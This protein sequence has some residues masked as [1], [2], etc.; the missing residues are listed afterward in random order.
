MREELQC[1]ENGAFLLDLYGV[2]KTLCEWL[3]IEITD[4]KSLE[5]SFKSRATGFRVLG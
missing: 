3:K 1:I 5:K 4:V 2:W